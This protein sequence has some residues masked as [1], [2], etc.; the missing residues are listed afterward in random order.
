MKMRKPHHVP[1][2]TQSIAILMEIQ[3][4]IGTHGYVFPSM[5]SRTRPMSENTLNAALRRLGHASNEMTAHGFRAMASTLL[6]ES[7]KWS[8]DA[9]ERALAHGDNDKVRAAYHRG[10]HW[11]ERVAMAQWWSSLL[12]SL[13]DGAT[14]LPFQVAI[15]G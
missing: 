4:I 13:R 8:Y 12:D 6:N 14:N 2:S 15:V 7:G 10:T 3:S 1:L 9:I 11:K 5:R